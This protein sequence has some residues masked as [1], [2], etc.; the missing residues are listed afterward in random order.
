MSEAGG[1]GDAPHY[2]GHR[3]RLRERLLGQGGDSLADYEV[4]ERLRIYLC[5]WMQ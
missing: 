1:S 5:M 3:Q 2:L 4:L